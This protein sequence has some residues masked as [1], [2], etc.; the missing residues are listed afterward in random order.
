MVR[1]VDRTK[2]KM[3]GISDSD[4][5]KNLDNQ[6][7]VKGHSVFL[8]SA[9]FS[10][11]SMMQGI[12]TLS[13]TLSE[14]IAATYCVQ[15]MMYIKKIVGSIKL[16]VKYSMVIKFDNKGTKDLMNHCGALVDV[17]NIFTYL[18]FH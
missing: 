2:F 4:T 14:L 3:K 12:M 16:I 9:P 17:R 13:V 8:I 7:S 10:M 1:K 5:A 15:K 6:R 11:K 18:F